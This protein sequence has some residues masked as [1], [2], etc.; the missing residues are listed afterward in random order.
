VKVE[1]AKRWLPVVIIYFFSKLA[2]PG[3]VLSRQTV[4][5]VAKFSQ[6]A[7][8]TQHF[9]SDA[10]SMCFCIFYS[11]SHAIIFPPVVHHKVASLVDDENGL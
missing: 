8:S 5:S 3:A 6:S 11:V 2:A 4:R 1:L 7:E 10:F 9:F